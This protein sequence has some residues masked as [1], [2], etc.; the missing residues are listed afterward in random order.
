[1]K[2][3]TK[4]LSGIELRQTVVAAGPY[5]GRISNVE[6]KPQIANP[7]KTNLVVEVTILNPEV[8]SVKGE[9]VENKGI[10]LTRNISMTETE[11]Y[12][13]ARRYKELAVA[14]GHPAAEDDTV[15]FNDQDMMNQDVEVIVEVEQA[16]SGVSSTTGKSFDY[17]ERNGIKRFQK[18]KDAEYEAPPF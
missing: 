16:V 1:M 6:V 5:Y 12:D 10:R 11:N 7:A 18:I 4:P 15:D 17:P 2:L 14:I 9:V 3:N 8:T 13:P